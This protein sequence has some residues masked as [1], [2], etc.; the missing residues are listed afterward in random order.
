[1][2]TFFTWVRTLARNRRGVA[3]TEFAYVAPVI[4]ALGMYGLE[5]TN[6][7]IVR[8]KVSQAA[9]N[10]ADN[11]SRMGDMNAL[12]VK[13]IR[14]IDINDSLA[15]LRSQTASYKLTTFGR[16]IV[17]SLERNADGGQWIHWQR[18]IG[19]KNWP[20]SFGVAGDGVTGTAFAGMG[21]TGQKITAPNA[22]GVMFVEIAYDYQPLFSNALLGSQTIQTR[23]AFVVR[24][25]RNFA[26]EKNPDNPSPVVPNDEKAICTVFAA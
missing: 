20:S 22:S 15:A 16:V 12:G 1:V 26:D 2:A 10:L 18:C 6:M 5:V 19:Q 11:V 21:P 14:E 4:V 13:S 25:Q 23:A 8:M 24:D 17:S 7:A 3:L 9:A